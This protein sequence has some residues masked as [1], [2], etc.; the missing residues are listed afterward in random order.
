MHT[1]SSEFVKTAVRSAS[2]PAVLATPEAGSVFDRCAMVPRSLVGR[3]LLR[4]GS[5]V[6]GF[7][8]RLVS[9]RHCTMASSRHS[10]RCYSMA[11]RDIFEAWLGMY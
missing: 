3:A 6:R 9:R 10:A 11:R 4:R 1:G 8:N 7:L 5:P 2:P